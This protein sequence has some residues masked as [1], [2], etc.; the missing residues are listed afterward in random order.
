[1]LEYSKL[2][3]GEKEEDWNLKEVITLFYLR[4][5]FVLILLFD[6]LG[7]L[8]VPIAYLSS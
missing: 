7:R 2:K 8:C 5:T 3:F 6:G 1:M 4:S